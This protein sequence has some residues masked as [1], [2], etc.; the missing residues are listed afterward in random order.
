MTWLLLSPWILWVLY[1]AVMRLK[2]V[3][4]AGKLTT[5]MKVFGYP[6]LFVGL[7]V[8]FVVNVVF[9]TLVFLQFP[10]EMTLSRRLWKL[11]NGDEGWRKNWAYWIRSQLLDS[12]DPEGVHRG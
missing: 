2:Q 7:A 4:D 8:D 10:H 11:S 9:G 12:I 6:A 3:R 5:A 1:A